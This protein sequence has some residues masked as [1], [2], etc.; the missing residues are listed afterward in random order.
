M[1]YK[2]L[3]DRILF[4]FI[5][6]VFYLISFSKIYLIFFFITFIYFII[7]Y[8]CLKFFKI[9]F[10]II[11]SYLFISFI[12][13]FIY[14]FNYYD[15]Y[16]FNL[17]IAIII[18]FDSFSYFSGIKYGKNYIFKKIS[19]KKSLEGYLGGI[20]STNFIILLVIYFSKIQIE[21]LHLIIF[22]NSIIIFSIIGDLTQSFFKRKNKIKNSSSFLPGHGG[23]FDRFDSFISAIFLLYF[24][25]YFYL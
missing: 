11:I 18:I 17:F 22:I 15:V 24:Y 25:S 10:Y 21:I 16:L 5:L 8:E 3:F 4:S 2:N 20:I 23:F 9:Y 13:F 1:V 6:I 14:F 19:P 12:C 7:F